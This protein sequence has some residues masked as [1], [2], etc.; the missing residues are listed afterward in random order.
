[1][2]IFQCALRIYDDDHRN[3]RSSEVEIYNLMRLAFQ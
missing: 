3:Y 2:K 1:M